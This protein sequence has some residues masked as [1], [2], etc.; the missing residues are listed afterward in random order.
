MVEND[1]VEQ[2]FG[3]WHATDIYRA[4]VDDVTFNIYN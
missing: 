1:A 2:V 4:Q 3:E